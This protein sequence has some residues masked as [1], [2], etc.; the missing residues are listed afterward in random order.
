MDRLND[1]FDAA[2]NILETSDK[3]EA[4][5]KESIEK[6]KFCTKI[7]ENSTFETR[8]QIKSSI[9]KANEEMIE[10]VSKN[11][12]ANLIDANK[13]AIAAAQQY[14]RAV[15]FTVI[16]ISAICFISLTLAG[17]LFWSILDNRVPN[18]V[19]LNDLMK[20]GIIGSCDG[21][22]CSRVV[23]RKDYFA[24]NANGEKTYYY[25]LIPDY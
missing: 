10:S 24:Q 13:I 9:K 3:N 14:E 19:G 16:K 8:E 17:I 5:F 22:P 2:A 11:I 1:L 15:K 21:K 6:I 18:H 25:V 20:Q 7:L 23:L 4:E 12:L